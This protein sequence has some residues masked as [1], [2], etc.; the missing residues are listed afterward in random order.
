MSKR[1]Y[2]IEDEDVAWAKKALA[3][4][5]GY[6]NE[7]Y[8]FLGALNQPIEQSD[9]GDTVEKL[10]KV[11]DERDFLRQRVTNEQHR[12]DSLRG[13]FNQVCTIRDVLADEVK[14]LTEKLQEKEQA[15]G[16]A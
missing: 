15:N 14:R 10:Q 5:E 3:P 7:A 16:D 11:R 8:L 4:W 9:M 6:T 12:F 1:L 13:T 2:L